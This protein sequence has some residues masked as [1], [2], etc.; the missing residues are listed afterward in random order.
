MISGGLNGGFTTLTDGHGNSISLAGIVPSLD[1]LESDTLSKSLVYIKNIFEIYISQVQAFLDCN[2]EVVLSFIVTIAIV[3]AI[4]AAAAATAASGGAG[5]PATVSIMTVLIAMIP[6]TANANKG[7]S[8]QN[9]SCE[10]DSCKKAQKVH[11]KAIN[12]D[13]ARREELYKKEYGFP[14]ASMDI[15]ACKK[16]AIVFAGVGTCGTSKFFEGTNERWKNPIVP[17]GW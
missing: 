6:A 1:F 12:V 8:N 4:L 11:L 3:L 14:D 7:A 15:C 16:G 13:G 17:Y 10:N 2:K 9:E 5:S